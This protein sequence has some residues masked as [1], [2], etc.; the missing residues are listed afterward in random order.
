LAYS[1]ISQLAYMFAA[2]GVGAGAAGIFHLFT[3]AW[4]KALMFLGAGSVIHAVHSNNM[5]EMGGLRKFMPITFKTFFVGWIAISGIPPLAGFFSK[6]EI[7]TEAYRVGARTAEHLPVEAW[8]GFVVYGVGLLTA[9][10][11]AFYMTRAV[12]LTFFG[13]YRGHGHPHESPRAITVPLMILAGL[14]IVGGWVGWPGWDSGFTSWVRI[15]VP[16]GEEAHVASAAIPLMLIS[17]VTAGLGIFFGRRLYGGAYAQRDP[18]EK[19]GWFHTL[20]VNKYYLDELYYRGLVYPIRDAISRAMYWVNQNVLDGAV[21]GAAKVARSTA[22]GV[23]DVVDQRVIDGTVNGAGIGTRKGSGLLKYIQSGDV[24]RYAA[25][26]FAGV[27]IL[28]FLFTRF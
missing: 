21:N 26:L 8:V 19:L 25:I 15:G 14:S 16:A 3:H 24:Q 6:D 27:A 18:L 28:A 13:E 23:Y 5:S 7:L 12:Y 1:T 20:L 10:L 11:T 4:F 22:Q 9:G 17:V 2:L